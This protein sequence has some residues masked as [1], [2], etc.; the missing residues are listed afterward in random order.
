MKGL[1][2]NGGEPSRK[3][4]HDDHITSDYKS[5]IVSSM[6]IIKD[7]SKEVNKVEEIDKSF[8]QEITS[9]RSFQKNST[10]PKNNAAVGKLV[11][12][13]RFLRNLNTP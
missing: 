5:Q 4:T 6:K 11:K 1:Y 12:L 3:L 10:L 8:M 7:D 9:Y 13:L 2:Y